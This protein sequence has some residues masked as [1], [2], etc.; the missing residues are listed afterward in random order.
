MLSTAWTRT[1]PFWTAWASDD[2][3]PI[4]LKATADTG[5]FPE[6]FLEQE[7]L[8]L[9]EDIYKREYLG[10]PTG[11]RMGPFTWDL[12]EAAT[13]IFKPKVPPGPDFS[14][15]PEPP[16]VPVENPFRNLKP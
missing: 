16:P 10:I 6:E 9:G 1:D 5:I 8:A 12:Y 15:A 11:A 2:Q 14:P 4:R 7:R 13:Q 3:T